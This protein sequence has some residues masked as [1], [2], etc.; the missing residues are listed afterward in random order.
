MAAR[1]QDIPEQVRPYYHAMA[2]RLLWTLTDGD[3]AVVAEPVKKE[4]LSYMCAVLGMQP[5]SISV[6]SLDHHERTSWYPG[7]NPSLVANLRS[8]ISS[9]RPDGDWLISSYIRDR[10][11]VAWERGLGLSNASSDT[12]ADNMAELVNTK[13]V[14]RTLARSAG[15]PIADGRVVIRGDEMYDAVT[16]LLPVTGAVIVKQD[17]NSG[18][19]GNVFVTSD[20]DIRGDGARWSVHTA[21][22]EKT[23][24]RRALSE[25]GLGAPPAIPAGCSPAKYIVEVFHPRSLSFY[26][27]LSVPPDAPPRLCNYGDLRMTPLWSG[28]EIPARRLTADQRE[29]LCAQALRLAGLAQ[30]IGY[31]GHFD[32]DVILTPGGELIFNEFNGRAGGATHMDVLCRRLLGDDYLDQVVLHTRNSVQAPEFRKLMLSLEENSL[33]FEHARGTGIIVTQDNT[34]RTGTIEYVSVGRS[35]DEAASYERLLEEALSCA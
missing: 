6:L 23:E 33:H 24:I 34:A 5:D 7:H 19:D 32:C 12:F 15:F 25:A 21:G 1:L 27:E 13:S 3:I 9:P 11:V 26:A 8:R 29:R 18:G 4:F 35:H 28:F 17:M 22:L 16:E 31:S 20:P 30:S 14:F 2:D 10:D